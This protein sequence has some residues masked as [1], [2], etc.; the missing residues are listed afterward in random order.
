M[1]TPATSSASLIPTLADLFNKRLRHP[2]TDLQAGD[3]LHLGAPILGFP[4]GH[5]VPVYGY[6]VQY[7]AQGRPYAVTAYVRPLSLNEHAVG[8]A[9]REAARYP[10][11]NQQEQWFGAVL[12]YLTEIDLTDYAD[13]LRLERL[14]SRLADLLQPEPAVSYRQAA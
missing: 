10:S 12:L 2:I 4:K 13:C 14:P 8:Y 6:C 9:Q 7:D 5:A 3:N 1:R 11:A